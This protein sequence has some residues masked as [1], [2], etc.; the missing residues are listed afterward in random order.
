MNLTHSCRR[1]AELLSQ[2]MDEPLGWLDRLRLRV[3]LSMCDN[4]RHVAQQLEAVKELSGE[5]FHLDSG[6]AM[7]AGSPAPADT[8]TPRADR[9]RR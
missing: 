9:A 8:L 4:C 7:N 6:P 5:L 1:V 3:H 2:R